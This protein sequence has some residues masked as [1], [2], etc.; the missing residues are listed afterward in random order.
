MGKLD[1]IPEY[2]CLPMDYRLGQVAQMVAELAQ[3]DPEVGRDA[4][5]ILEAPTVRTLTG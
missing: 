1:L 4:I 5:S 3:S 2:Q